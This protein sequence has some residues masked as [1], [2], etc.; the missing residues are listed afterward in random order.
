MSVSLEL[1]LCVILCE[2]LHV[3]LEL[4][5]R[6]CPVRHVTELFIISTHSSSILQVWLSLC[7][8]LIH[9]FGIYYN[10]YRI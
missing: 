1:V 6:L 9:V 8:C 2:C 3:S 7:P 4:V 5:L 10:V